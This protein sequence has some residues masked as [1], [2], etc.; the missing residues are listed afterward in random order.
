[1]T[2]FT[3]RPAAAADLPQ[4]L[5]L[6]AHLDETMYGAARDPGE[7]RR[8][9][10][11]RTILSDSNQRLFVADAG[12][13]L[14]G[15]AHLIVLQHFDLQLRRSA[16]IEGV[17]VDEPWRAKGVGAAL[18]REIAAAARELGC[19]KLALSSNLARSGAHRFYSRLGWKRTHYGYSLD[20]APPSTPEPGT[21]E[22]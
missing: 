20:L 2:A 21:I 10:A 4:L 14:V 22:P 7:E 15:T 9:Q 5:S 11:F 18:M 17:V 12:G 8:R 16:I 1:M 13:R 3:V 19:Y 6:L